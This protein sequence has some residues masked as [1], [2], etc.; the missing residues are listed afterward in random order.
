ME[1]E[2]PI[3]QVGAVDIGLAAGKFSFSGK[4]NVPAGV[5]VGALVEIETDVFFDFLA[6][7]IPGKVDD[8]IFAVLKEV[9]KKV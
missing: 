3:G 5:S 9:C 8:A 7:K 4:A 6:A 2:I 1:K